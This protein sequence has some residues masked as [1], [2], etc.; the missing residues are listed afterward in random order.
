MIRTDVPFSWYSYLDVPL[1]GT[2]HAMQCGYLFDTFRCYIFAGHLGLWW[3]VFSQG[4]HNDVF[5]D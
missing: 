4:G 5:K 3:L 1:D 2:F